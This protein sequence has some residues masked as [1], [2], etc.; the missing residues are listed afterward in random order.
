MGLPN[1]GSWFTQRVVVG[2]GDL[3]VT[4][5]A[6]SI[7]STYALGSCIG[8]AAYD[9]TLKVGGILHF[10]LPDSRISP[11]KAFAQ[12]AMFA[13]TGLRQFFQQLFTFGARPAR[14]QLFVAGGAKV[15]GGDDTLRIGIRNTEAILDFLDRNDLPLAY[16]ELGGTTNRTLHLA[17]ADGLLT[18]KTPHAESQVNLTADRKEAAVRS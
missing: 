5:A 8:V 3:V 14:L 2:V 13:D 17:L 16:T 10:M 6:Q 11:E 1:P 18:L 9:S 15:L 7:L 12:P 4:N